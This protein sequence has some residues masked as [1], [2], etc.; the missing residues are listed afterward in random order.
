MNRATA[1]QLSQPL[2]VLACM[3]RLTRPSV[4]AIAEELDISPAAVKRAMNNL[5]DNWGVKWT[6]DR[7]VRAVDGGTGSYRIDSLGP[8][9]E[10]GVVKTV[11]GYDR[12]CGT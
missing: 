7:S 2:L 3:I 11:A 10:S 6:F 5:R 12:T 4:R 1:H 9:S 8:F